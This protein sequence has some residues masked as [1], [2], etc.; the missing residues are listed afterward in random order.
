MMAEQRKAR[1]GDCEGTGW[2]TD[3]IHMGD[4]VGTRTYPCGRCDGIGRLIVC[5]CGCGATM[6][7]NGRDEAGRPLGRSSR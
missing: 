6:P 2:I 7:D 3:R 4:R 5:S 1:C